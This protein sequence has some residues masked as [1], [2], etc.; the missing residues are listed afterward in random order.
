MGGSSI[1]GGGQSFVARNDVED[2]LGKGH[3]PLAV[4]RAW[5]P[6]SISSM[7][8]SAPCIEENRLAFSLARN[9]PKKAR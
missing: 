8:L 6:D 3:L 5:S 1:P 2:F 9:S 7:F 4:D